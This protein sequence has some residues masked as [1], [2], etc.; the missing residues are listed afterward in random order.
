[1]GKAVITKGYDLPAKYIIHAVGPIWEG[2]G[3]NE[4]NLLRSAYLYSLKLALEEGIGSISFPLISSGIYGFPKDK[5]LKI[6]ISAISEFLLK[7]DM[8][9]YLVIYGKDTVLLSEK[10]FFEI[11]EYIDDNYVES[12]PRVLEK[13]ELQDAVY[14]ESI[15]KSKVSFK[16]KR[17]LANMVDEAD[18]S[19]S[20]ML[21]RLV[22]D[23]GITDVEAYK[24]ANIDRRLFS[25]IKN[26]KNYS[27]SKI[28][29]ISFAISL[30]LNLDETE[31]LLSRAGYAL[32]PSSKFDII[33]QF[34]IEEGNYDIFQINEALF[35][36]DQDLLGV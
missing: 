32:S 36:F 3:N 1:M 12:S 17:E 31:D 29:A 6:A 21:L 14:E 18:E 8:D 9:I 20:R 27:P 35:S 10:L 2:G 11:E 5:A 30:K 28:T 34:F 19:F 22:D 24:G 7:H 16:K 13:Y 15:L 23:K 26:N 4:E 25:K 33:I